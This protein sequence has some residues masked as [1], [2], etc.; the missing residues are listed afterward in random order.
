MNDNEI[1]KA[2]ECCGNQM[3]LCN[4][5]QCKSKTLGDAI[6]LIKRQKAEIKQLREE[7]HRWQNAFEEARKEATIEKRIS[8]YIIDAC[9]EEMIG[10][11]T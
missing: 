3:Y 6:D 2:L 7:S 1:I 5:M 8:G 10:W 9:R 11:S 4:D